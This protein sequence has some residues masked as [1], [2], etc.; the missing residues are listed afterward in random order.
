MNSSLHFNLCKFILERNLGF[1]IGP[2][3]PFSAYDYVLCFPLEVHF[4]WTAAWTMPK[5]LYLITRYISMLTVGVLLYCKILT[6]LP[7]DSFS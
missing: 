1:D 4:I 6:C 3:F 7:T 2:C 5:I